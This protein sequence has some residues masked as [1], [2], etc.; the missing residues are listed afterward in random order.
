[1]KKQI[2]RLELAT[3]YDS[4]NMGP[5]GLSRQHDAYLLSLTQFETE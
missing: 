2:G 4:P 3:S 5:M 1:M